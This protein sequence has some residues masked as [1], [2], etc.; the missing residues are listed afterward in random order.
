MWLNGLL[1]FCFFT[2]LVVYIEGIKRKKK[3]P[4]YCEILDLD[5]TNNKFVDFTFKN[6]MGKFLN[7]FKLININPIFKIFIKYLLLNADL[8]YKILM[9]VH[10]KFDC[11]L[12][13]FSS[14]F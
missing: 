9:N 4:N 11:N 13:L 12:N 6:F 8:K 10:K 2:N 14:L 3:L 1:Y 5:N 7:S